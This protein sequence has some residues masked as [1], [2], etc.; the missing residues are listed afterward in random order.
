MEHENIN[1]HS[2]SNYDVRNEIIYI[3]KVL[4][5]NLCDYDDA[6]ILVS[7]DIVPAAL[8]NPTPVALKNC[9]SFTK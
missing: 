8:N 5:S 1:D 2:N 4:K 6:Y 7:G 9:V 3:T